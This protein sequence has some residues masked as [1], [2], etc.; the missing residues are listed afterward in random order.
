MQGHSIAH[1]VWKCGP[2]GIGLKT[3]IAKIDSDLNEIE[4]P[5]VD[6]ARLIIEFGIE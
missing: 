4:T 2:D 3:C 5:C 1:G 6:E